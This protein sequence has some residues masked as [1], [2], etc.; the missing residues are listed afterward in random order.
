[1]VLGASNCTNAEVTRVRSTS[2]TSQRSSFVDSSSSAVCPRSSYRDQLRSAVAMEARVPARPPLAV[3]IHTGY[4][5][6]MRNAC[7]VALG[8]TMCVVAFACGGTATTG[9]GGSSGDGGQLGAGGTT[10]SR[11]G[12]GMAAAT[13][14]VGG[15]GSGGS[16]GA[17]GIGAGGRVVCPPCAA[18]PHPGCIVSG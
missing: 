13:A 14:G 3:G 8:V 7:H 10:V 1:M 16:A 12:D 9:K 11:G 2:Q 5:V 6:A 18:P 4:A 17:G 15:T